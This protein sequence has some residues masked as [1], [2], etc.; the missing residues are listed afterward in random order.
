[1]NTLISSWN[2]DKKKKTTHN[3]LKRIVLCSTFDP[4]IHME[5]INSWNILS[6]PKS[7]YYRSYLG[8]TTVF[9]WKEYTW[10]QYNVQLLICYELQHT[11]LHIAKKSVNKGTSLSL[12]F[13]SITMLIET[14]DMSRHHS[15]IKYKQIPAKSMTVYFIATF[16]LF[17]FLQWQPCMLEFL[18]QFVL[19]R[20]SSLRNPS[21]VS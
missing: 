15:C 21:P 10:L 19:E 2:K 12:T 5:V 8:F 11:K 16:F 7:D 3:P 17:L 20:S 14:A 18:L 13:Q 6:H 9:F 4:G 1:M